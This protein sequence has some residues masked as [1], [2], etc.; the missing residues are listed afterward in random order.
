M[1]ISQR[2]TMRGYLYLQPDYNYAHVPQRYDIRSVLLDTDDFTRD[3]CAAGKLI[4]AIFLRITA[5]RYGSMGV[6]LPH[7]NRSALKLRFFLRRGDFFNQNAHDDN[8]SAISTIYKSSQFFMLE[9]I[10]NYC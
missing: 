9:L 10:P 7:E 5:A 8:C 4:I 6:S 3:Y 1:P 2:R